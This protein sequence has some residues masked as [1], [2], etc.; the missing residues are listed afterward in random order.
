[1]NPFRPLRTRLAAL[2]RKRQLDTEMDEEMRSHL[3]LRTQAN[4][5]AGMDP[6]TA[7]RA[8]HR[9]FGHTDSLQELCRDQRGV[10]LLEQF[11]QDIRFGGR[12]LARNRVFTVV[13]V[14]T[15]ALGI[16]ANTAIFSFVNAILLRPLPYREPGQLVMLFESNAEE[17]SHRIPLSPPVLLEWRRQT[18]LFEGLAAHREAGFNLTGHGQPG[19]LHGS[20]V[21]A[22][23]FALLGVRPVLG[24][25]FRPEEETFGRHRVAL[26]AQ[27]LWQDRFGGDPAIVGQTITLNDER[28]TVIGVMP[29]ATFFPNNDMALWT[30]L[31][32]APDEIAHRHSHNYTGYGRLKTGVSLRQ[33]RSELELDARRMAQADAPNQAWGGALESLQEVTVADSRTMLLVLLGAVAL[34]LLI[35]C[36]NIANLM[37]ARSAARAREFGL[38]SALGA[39]RNRLIR[40]LLT[41]SL[42]I[43]AMG[44]AGGLLVAR[45]GLGVLVRLSPPDLPR[46]WE[47]IHLDGWALGFTTAVTVITAVAIGLVPALHTVSRRLARELNEGARSSGAGRGRQR[48]RVGLVIGEVALSLM[49]LIGAGLM[50]RS[51]GRLL[52]QNLGY[53]PER[54]VTMGMGLTEGRYPDLAAGVRFYDTVLDR[55]RA[56]PGVESAALVAGLPL[57]HWDAHVGVTVQGAPAR[58]PGLGSA[59]NYA[60]ISPGYFQT[61]NIALLQGRDFAAQDRSG[62]PPVVIVNETFVREFALGPNPLGRRVTLSEGTDGAEIVG[63]VRDTKRSDLAD[64]HQGEIYRPYRQNCWGQM[65]LV[66]RTTRE[67]TELGHVIR[68][69]LDTIDRDVPLVDLATMDQIVSRSVAQRRLPLRLLGG[70]AGMALLLAAVGLYGVLAYG[71]AQRQQEIGIRMALGAQRSDVRRLI[72]GEG[73]RLVGWGIVLGLGGALALTRIIS[74]LLYQVKP[75]DPGTIVGVSLLLAAVGLLACWLPARRA[76]RT[77]PMVALRAE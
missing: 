16:G 8:A 74:S 56:L 66:L 38:R 48:F 6:E 7:H 20:Q 25:D 41:E 76:V 65:S 50:L 17:G 10:T 54:V 23:T 42:L 73:M 33:A 72:V 59:V 26:L 21:S 29:P 64:R 60:Q 5:A 35:A 75:T 11:V 57:N 9:Q 28:F 49:L 51:F 71:V 19:P 36:A 46:I 30:P 69:E 14:A 15:L 13:A 4:I 77:D 34:V 37:L 53:N 62:S 67:P 32:F 22:N 12:M 55:A 31:A 68:A 39:G 43:A 61:L 45:A 40:Q 1:M 70:F 63:V 2:F 44:G 27:E 3:E 47:G 24:R 18:T 58:A 52:S